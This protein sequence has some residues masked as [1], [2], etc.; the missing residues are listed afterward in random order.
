MIMTSVAIA[1][2]GLSTA[3]MAITQAD[4]TAAQSAVTAAQA[5]VATAQAAV[6]TKQT[7]VTTAQTNLTNAQAALT[8]QKNSTVVGTLAYQLAKRQITSAT[9]TSKI[10]ALSNTVTTA[11]A[12]LTAAKNA[13]TAA[14]TT[15]TT[16][17]ATLATKTTAYN[18]I[19]SQFNAQQAATAS[20]PATTTPT[21]TTPVTT[22]PTTTA[23]TTSTPTTAPTY[24]PATFSP[25]PGAPLPLLASGQSYT[26]GQLLKYIRTNNPQASF[27]VRSGTN[28]ISASSNA[29]LQS[30][31]D[32]NMGLSV[33]LQQ[34]AALIT[35]LAANGQLTSTTKAN[36]QKIMLC[37]NIS[38]TT[39]YLVKPY[40]GVTKTTTSRKAGR[41]V[42]TTRNPA[43]D[44]IK[45]FNFSQTITPAALG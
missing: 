21:T 37:F 3:G 16:A 5:A 18:T 13:L 9:Y 31:I 17:K 28:Q 40:P 10:T 32:N 22:T 20:T 7:A 14:Q 19:L 27:Y 24:T 1:L 2:V 43:A 26:V 44:I 15:L 34:D 11:T 8:K 29:T 23:P 42:T 4:V 30:L 39:F 6:T 35:W 38:G 36:Y 12:A 33:T 41:T 45:N 25:I